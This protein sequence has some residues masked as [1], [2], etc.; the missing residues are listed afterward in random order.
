M[1]TPNPLAEKPVEAAASEAAAPAHTILIVDD[2]ATDRHLAGAIAQQTEGWKAVFASNGKEAL[3]VLQRQTPDVVLTDMLMPEMDGLELVRAIHTKHPL[4]PVILMT[5]Y[6][7]EELAIQALRS[8]A[9][10]YVPKKSLA[11]DLAETLDGVLAASQTNRREQ[12]VLDC[13]TRHETH[14]QLD[15]DVALVAPI[16]GHLEQQM[17]RLQACEPSSLVLV[18]VALHE[19][20]T[21]A[22]LHGS[23]DLDSELRETDEPAYYRLAAERRR[24][25]PW[26]ERRVFVSA[27]LTPQEAVFVVRDEGEGFDPDSLPDPTDPANL[28][29]ICGRGLLLIQTFM[30][31]VEHNERGNQITMIKRR[32]RQ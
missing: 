2:S 16:V 11:R 8:G 30:D 21:N 9:A 22:I 24:Q 29:R 25:P 1:S 3:E 12:R 14:Y 26:S 7:S 32:G 28:G 23:L 20:L 6:G 31:R 4:V 10:S 17:E 19:A 18:G 27:T 15:N 13:L 5:A